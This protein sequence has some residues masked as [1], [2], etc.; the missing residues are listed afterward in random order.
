MAD[1]SY[2]NMLLGGTNTWNLW[3]RTCLNRRLDLTEAS[4]SGLPLGGVDLRNVNLHG[5]DLSDA[6]LSGAHLN[7]SD[8]SDANLTGVNLSWAD[9]RDVK[10]RFTSL[11]GVNLTG[12]NLSGTHLI[13]ADLSFAELSRADLSGANLDGANLSNA[14]LTR[15]HLSDAHL[16]KADL[17]EA[18]LSGADLVRADLCE[19]NLTGANLTEADLSEARLLAVN[20]QGARLIST[21]LLR[22]TLDNCNIYGVSAWDVS[23]DD[24]KQTNLRITGPGEPSITID[25]LEVAQL[26]YMLLHNEKLRTILDTITSKVVLILGR[27]SPERKPVLDALREALRNHPNG[28][29]PVLFDFA[30]QQ[31]KPVL[32]TVKTLAHLARFVIADLT[33]PNMVRS[34]LTYIIP[35]IPTVPVC[36]LI[37]GDAMLPTE[38]ESWMTYRTFL[39]VHR[40]DSLQQL[41]A[42]LDEAVIMPVEDLVRPRRLNGQTSS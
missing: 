33:D 42:S 37:E 35:N 5:A 23:L 15:A 14:Y 25:N 12:V 24:A 26:L 30:P 16:M 22:A 18:D 36:S 10:L 41:L 19:A 20:L 2:L 4:L 11:S 40:Y 29:I 38:Y 21:R 34:E 31:D 7:Q 1:E 9:L 3:R 6:Q 13:E 39:S 17:S 8:L 27:F 28:Y 32:E